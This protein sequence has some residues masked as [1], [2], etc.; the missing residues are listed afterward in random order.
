[1]TT[2]TLDN[3][4]KR[5][6]NAADYAVADVSLTA[7]DGEI[8]ALLGPSGG[9]KST[10]LKMIAGLLKPTSGD[11]R[12]DDASVLAVPA[13]E[14][15]AVMVF[16]NHLLFPH[17]T[18][19][20]NIGFGLKMRGISRKEI[21]RRVQAMLERV[22]LPHIGA[23]KPHQLSGGQQQRVALARALVT[24]PNLLLLDE[25]L[26]NLDAHLRDDMRQLIMSIQ[27]ETQVTTI[28]V[29]HD[30]QEA[31]VLADKIGLL[32]DGTLHQVAPPRHFYEHPASEAVARF[33]G[34]VNFIPATIA[35][36]H[37][38]TSIGTLSLTD[39]HASRVGQALLTIRPEQVRLHAPSDA[40]NTFNATLES[41]T[42]LGT[43]TRYT[44][45]IGEIRLTA[46]LVQADAL[47]A[48]SGKT[49][50]VQLPAE[51]LWSLPTV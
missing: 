25:P 41:C 46:L 33:F 32:L 42:Y 19:A 44:L 12:F 10:V 31:V 30:Q 43:Q 38:Q 37:A 51:K 16:Q 22:Q 29:T 36:G 13:E 15:G 48:A 27:R 18:A 20:E 1:M 9:G 14:R 6:A 21:D 40:P 28:L 5:Y 4:S 26:T 39:D 45:R 49:I 47:S 17:M 11:I 50:T 2:L 35:N 24:E 8:L 7:Q 3:L 23:R 34:G